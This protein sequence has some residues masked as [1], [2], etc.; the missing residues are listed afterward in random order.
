M[1]AIFC[2]PLRVRRKVEG[3]IA[4]SG[5]AFA[6]SPRRLVTAAHVVKEAGPYF[7]ELPSAE[8]CHWDVVEVVSPDLGCD[9]AVLHLAKA[10]PS[11][12]LSWP[13]LREI[14]GPARFEVVIYGYPDVDP[15]NKQKAIRPASGTVI[16][17]V[18]PQGN[19]TLDKITE[20]QSWRGAS[21]SAI[22]VDDQIVGVVIQHD[23][24]VPSQLFGVS[25]QRFRNESWFE[26]A[27]DDP[28]YVAQA[29]L[30]AD[31]ERITGAIVAVLKG[32]PNLCEILAQ[33][34]G[35][36]SALPAITHE[37][38]HK[39]ASEVV[40]AVDITLEDPD[41]SPSDKEALRG[42]FIELLPFL[43]DWRQTLLGRRRTFL[44]GIATLKVRYG[45]EAMAEVLVAGGLGR[46]CLFHL[47]GKGVVG[48]GMVVFPNLS[49]LPVASCEGYT[50]EA[51]AAVLAN[52]LGIDTGRVDLIDEVAIQLER[53]ADRTRRR[54]AQPKPRPP[55]SDE[56][57]APYLVVAELRAAKSG[58]SDLWKLA[59]E[60]KSGKLKDL[61]LVHLAGEGLE[62]QAEQGFATTVKKLV[63]P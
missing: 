21:G 23:Q 13:S 1:T 50:L 14:H 48:P 16:G 58:R 40:E 24:V 43:G 18:P 38:L 52:R 3:G 30:N 36:Q 62:R 29:S 26:A 7:V 57:K 20:L 34:L 22:W 45:D 37:I 15:D 56:K 49:D 4:K 2:E 41:V 6:L 19:L 31:M 55:T 42:L 25:V 61:V 63:K 17:P 5:T 10:L 44:D 27:L 59:E 60:F 28:E 46:P 39:P 12:G 35:T 47:D 53:V 9:V 54:L 11:N 8:G 33:N 32:R 51:V